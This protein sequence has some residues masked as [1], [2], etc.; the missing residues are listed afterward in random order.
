MKKTSK[1]LLVLLTL[2]FGYFTLQGATMLRVAK[3][4]YVEGTIT[5]NTIWTLVDSP[6]VVSKDLIIGLDATLTIE[7][8]VEV[9]FGENLSL[10]VEGALIAIGEPN[11]MIKFTSN[12]NTPAAGDWDTLTFKGIQPSSMSN[13][14]VEYGLTGITVENSILTIQNSLVRINSENGISAENATAQIENSIIANNTLAG[15]QTAGSN[16]FTIQ[17]NIIETNGNGIA[18]TGNLTST[19]TVNQ[20]R[21]LNNTNGI[22]LEAENYDN[23]DIHSNTISANSHG[24]HVSTNSSTNITHNYI[25]NND[26][27]IY[28]EGGTNHAANFND[29]YGN[30][31]GIEVATNGIVDATRNYWGD[32]TGPNHPTLNPNG[33]GDHL[34]A[35]PTSLDF[36]YWLTAPIDYNNTPPR[37]VLWTDKIKVAPNQNVTFIGTDSN[38]TDAYGNGRVDQ[39]LFN[40]GEGEE[41]SWTTLSLVNHAYTTTGTYNA[42]LIVMDDF[43]AESTETLAQVNVQDL[44]ALDAQITLSIETIG[45]NHEVNVTVHAS[46]SAGI[47]GNANVGIFFV[48]KG[49]KLAPISG[50]TQSNGDFYAAFTTP[51]V[52]EIRDLRII[53]RVSAPDHVDGSDYAY[54]KI[55]PPLTVNVIAEP[56]VVRSEEATTLTI[57]VKNSLLEPIT[58]AHLSLTL[59][60]DNGTALSYSNGT[61]GTNGTAAFNVAAPQTLTEI[62]ILVNVIANKTGYDPAYGEGNIT[63]TPKIL[64]ADV[65]AYPAQILSETNSNV[66]VHVTCDIVA[67]SDV[68]VTLTSDSG[69]NFAPATAATDSNGFASFNFVA[70][71]T[72]SEDG[73]NTTISAKATLSGYVTSENS[74]LVA[75]KPKALSVEITSE[76]NATYSEKMLNITFRV[77]YQGRP[78]QDA[79]VEITSENAN[80]VK[81][82]TG[83]DGKVVIAFKTPEVNEQTNISITT[84][85]NAEGYLE[86]RSLLEMAVMPRTFNVQMTA[87]TVQSEEI[88]TVTLLVK[89]AEDSTPVNGTTVTILSFDGSYATRNTDPE[90]T[91]IFEFATPKTS[92]DLT[93]TLMANVTKNGYAS[94]MSQTTITVTA[95]KSEGWPLTMVLLIAVIPIVIVSIVAVLIKLKII[96]V[97]FG[98]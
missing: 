70:P 10:T 26:A 57:S 54:V 43:G 97:S 69:G 11:K 22:L 15:I 75:V 18:L 65:T 9:R 44:P 62:T 56:A 24:F 27:G 78:I 31:L 88:A 42:S 95:P 50:L 52:T 73:I 41:P 30:S 86:Y 37:A 89:C 60:L 98:D 29:I 32:K 6:F 48:L 4:T 40:F 3:A 82:F 49:E 38:D 80:T 20:N 14:V 45:S 67:V 19:M 28:Y 53:A 46:D 76:S 63:V 23:I 34:E 64:I 36:I 55:L 5:Q 39:Y 79:N 59:A 77:Q 96:S 94:G 12:R 33:K 87:P 85:V 66:T 25:L 61:T 16:Q 68:A 51:N 58:E 74:T 72:T 8:Q 91:C 1:S 84:I 93:L 7:P 83:T 13:C 71:R 90:G 81:G 35:S 17:N 47:V 92:S 21:I 2:V